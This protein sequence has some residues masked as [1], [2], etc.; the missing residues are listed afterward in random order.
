MSQR[1]PRTSQRLWSKGCQITAPRRS[2]TCRAGYATV[3]SVPKTPMSRFE[4][5]RFINFEQL[6]A[7]IK[8]IRD[9]L[10]R[11]LTY[12]EKVLYSHLD[13]P[14]SATIE[15]GVSNLELRPSRVACQDATSQM[16]LLQFMTAGL[17][18]VAVPTTIHCDHLITGR[19]GNDIDLAAALSSSKE[20]FDFLE[21][22]SQKYGIGYW[23]PGAGII[24][25][26]V[27]ENYAYPGGLMIGADSHTPN[28]GGL[29][30][31]AIGIGGADAVDVMSGQT[32]SLKSPSI[33]G[34]E[35][36]GKLSGWVSPKDI[37]LD[38]T[39]RLTVKGGTG[40]IIEY[41]GS[42]VH[43]LSCTGMATI[44]NMGAETGATTSIFPYTDAMGAYLNA[45]GRGYIRDRVQQR[46]PNLQADEGAEYDQLIKLD[47]SELEP[48]INGPFTPDLSTPVSKFGQFVTEN[49]WPQLTAG[50][51]GSCTNSSF[52]DMNRVASLAKQALDA[53]IKPKI[54]FI[55]TVGSEQ[56]RR[57][58]EKAGIVDILK[59]SGGT[60]LAN[61]CGP[62]SGSWTREDVKK[63]VSNS[64]I[65]SYNRNFTGRIDG[66]PETK[67]FI[68]SPEMV[69]VKTF[70]GDLKFDPIRDTIKTPDG[71]DFK[72]EPPFGSSLPTRYENADA[73]YKAPTGGVS[74]DVYID[75]DSERLQRLQPFPA[76]SGEDYR[77]LPILVKVKGKCTTDHITPAGPW[78]RFRGH[79]ENISE[80]TLIG[81]TN[82]ENDEV[83]SVRN[84]FTNEYGPI[85]QT[86]KDYKARG[87][88]WVIIG[89]SNY[90]EGSSREHAALQPRFLNGVAVIARSLARIHETNLKKQGLLALTFDDAA[91]YDRIQPPDRISLV[92]LDELRPG[93]QITMQVRRPDGSGWSCQLNH[94]FTDAQVQYFKHGSALNYMGHVGKSRAADASL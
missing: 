7:N 74:G 12:A 85:A 45:T 1:L 14:E 32:W 69:I 56:T 44:T 30:M 11:P 92:G 66:N 54:P 50:L 48:R 80:N 94:T 58:L 8:L 24:H 53:G 89:D 51:I 33:I 27:L 13:Q 79:L 88:P 81:A 61:A 78:F 21:K 84:V 31:A 90:G 49:N 91:D 68:A 67:S 4:N 29:G 87:Q 76:W 6:D 10:G 19:K 34:V 46:L 22:A 37:I 43:T 93:Q 72:F 60:I 25:Q 77:D 55:V 28:A 62:C 59:Q 18:K 16:A 35:L 47:L 82:A 42:G 57:T 63:G 41:F 65:S 40:S 26:V 39:R 70:A 3:A 86:A 17:D 20:V 73:T 23:G 52:E 36:T 5:D 9:R 64:V 2:R 38:I 75:P 71:K 83:N 15:R